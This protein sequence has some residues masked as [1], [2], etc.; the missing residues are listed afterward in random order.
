[1]IKAEAMLTMMSYQVPLGAVGVVIGF[2][3]AE[4]QEEDRLRVAFP[5]GEWA[6]KPE[7]LIWCVREQR[8]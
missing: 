7:E 3:K 5:N 2:G 4:D 8:R 1:M 6:F